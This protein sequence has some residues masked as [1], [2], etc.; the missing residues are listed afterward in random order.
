MLA[1]AHHLGWGRSTGEVLLLVTSA[2]AATIL[3]YLGAVKR[4][5]QDALVM[6]VLLMLLASPLLWAHY[7]ALLLIP[8]ALSFPRLSGIW[9]LPILMWPMPPRQ[10]V[11]GWEEALC[12]VLTAI[13]LAVVLKPPATN[14]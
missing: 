2:I 14:R 1:V 7:F 13:C 6:T 11:V 9:L 3:V 5:D 8:I 4:R 12:W 10:P